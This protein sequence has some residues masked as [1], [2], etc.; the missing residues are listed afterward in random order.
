MSATDYVV[1]GLDVIS[2]SLRP[3]NLQKQAQE[4]L[5]RLLAKA[6]KEASWPG[7]AAKPQWIDAGDGGYALFRGE[8]ERVLQTIANL[9]RSIN[10]DNTS[11]EEDARLHLRY[12]IHK[13]QILPW[14]GQ[15][16]K[17]YTGNALNNCSRL[18]AG[19][20]KKHKGQVVCSQAIVN[21]ISSFGQPN[22]IVTRIADIQDKHGISHAVYNLRRD[23]G[24]GVSPPASEQYPNPMERHQSI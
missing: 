18:L 23:P 1:L 11:R 16:G 2:Y 3:L 7:G 17:K 24:F 14:N 13:D 19:M 9:Q 4:T 22:V 12:A 15:L 8:E 6:I 5:D 21:A 20:S 10:D